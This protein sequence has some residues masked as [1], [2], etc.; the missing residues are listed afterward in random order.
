MF[1]TEQRPHQKRGFELLQKNPAF[2][3]FC[4]MRTGKTKMLLDDAS[5]KFAAGEIDLLFVVCPNDV[6]HNWVLREIPKHLSCPYWAMAV[7]SSM[8]VKEKRELERLAVEPSP[9]RLKVVAVNI[10]AIRFSRNP[11][12][13][14]LFY[15]KLLQE[16]RAMMVVD[17][18]QI[19]KTPTAQATRGA[20]QLA[21][22]A[23]FRRIATGTPQPQGPPDLFSQL[24][25]LSPNAIPH[26]TLTAF[27]ADFC[28]QKEIENK[29]HRKGDP[30]SPEFIKITVGFK[31]EDKLR[32]LVQ[33]WAYSVTLEEIQADVPAVQADPIYFEFTP[34]QRRMYN[35]LKRQAISTIENP[36]PHL[37]DDEL[38]EWMLLDANARV[39]SK[40]GL[41]AALR[42]LQLGGGFVND[43]DG[44][45]QKVESNRMRRLLDFIET[46]DS[47]EK[48]VIW[49]SFIP[50]IE[51]VRDTLRKV[52]GKAAVVDF[53]GATKA[54]AR[55][56]AIDR[57]TNDPECRFFVA[58]PAAAG[59]GIDLAAGRHMIWYTLPNYNYEVY[60]QAC[61]RQSG[62]LQTR[63]R[64]MTHLVALR[65]RDEK[66]MASMEEKRDREE[67]V[68]FAKETF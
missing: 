46:M 60:E 49:A 8:R 18:S 30:R 42:M 65:S 66:V 63:P 44:E 55:N 20:L 52:Y 57:Y 40:N 7:H 33:P 64:I 17:E 31:N 41:T 24:K 68:I 27:R 39:T 28:I 34:Q 6:Q 10:E 54:E 3:L 26:A 38:V 53:Y 21:K 12:P 48:V 50:E 1:K 43:D 61:A 19:I 22:L 25:F 29:H 56:E 67:K 59:R 51:E 16:H 36:P 9:D 2:A 5:A 62:P 23:P 15:K 4:K 37:S 11:T 35:E 32:E 58:N 14:F 45:L 47:N 13:K